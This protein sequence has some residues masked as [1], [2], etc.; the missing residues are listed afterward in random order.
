MAHFEV[1]KRIRCGGNNKEQLIR[2]LA[3]AN[4]KFN[5]YAQAL[6][7]LPAFSPTKDAETAELVRVKFSDLNL[8]VPCAMESILQRAASLGLKPCPLYLGAF[9]RLQYPDQPEDGYLTVA[10]ARPES[11]ENFPT[12]FYLRN[13]ENS[14][15][16]RGYRSSGASEWPLDNEFI[17]LK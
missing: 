1:F 8:N 5:D 7:L 6:F 13:Y 10:S 12:G 15:W 9:L 17:F 16:L 4:I 2:R 14:L 11:A 3:H